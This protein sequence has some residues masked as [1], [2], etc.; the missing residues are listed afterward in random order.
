MPRKCKIIYEKD[1]YRCASA[2]VK[3]CD[4]EG[5]FDRTLY[6]MASEGKYGTHRDNSLLNSGYNHNI[7]GIN[8]K[9][10]DDLKQFKDDCAD[11][12]DF[13]YF[14]VSDKREALSG[15]W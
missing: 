4:M 7:T 8:L 10:E 15:N 6:S 5:C 12:F 2:W 14:K 13:E 3:N 1:G 11:I 9:T